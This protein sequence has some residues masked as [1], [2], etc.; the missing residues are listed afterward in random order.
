MAQFP[1]IGHIA[2]TVSDASASRVWYSKLFGAE[3]V[4]DEDTGPFRHVVYKLGDT[5]FGLHQH[6]QPPAP[7]DSF[8]E[9]R[10]GLDHVSFHVGSRGELEKWRAKLDELGIANNAIND[11]PDGSALAFRDPDNNALELFAFP[12]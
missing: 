7:N 2:L 1:D 12:G 5:L 3:P 6:T 10:I 9:F 8:N 11:T 4:T